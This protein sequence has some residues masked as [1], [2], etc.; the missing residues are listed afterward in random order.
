MHRGDSRWYLQIAKTGYAQL[1]FSDRQ[2]ENW[3]FFPLLPL[4]IR[5]GHA[6]CGFYGLSCFLISNTF[7]F[8]CLLFLYNFLIRQGYSYETSDRAVWLLAFS[9]MSYFFSLPM[10]ESLFLCLTIAAFF[11]LSERRPLLSGCLMSLA[12]ASRP[13]GLLVLPAFAAALAMSPQ[14]SGRN[15]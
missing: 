2:E 12:V 7:F 10:S 8:L 15:K 5:A 13:T 6:M 3:A 1:P 4:L 9:P 14:I 11:A